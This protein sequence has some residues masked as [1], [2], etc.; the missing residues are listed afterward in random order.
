MAK[1]VKI[2]RPQLFG[3]I[4]T[5]EEFEFYTTE[6]F[7]LLKS[8]ELKTKVYKTYPLEDVAKAH[9]VSF[10]RMDLILSSS[11]GYSCG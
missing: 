1:N 7:R 3:Y 6:L 4:Q 9:E 11:L 10:N 8:G 5:R 2:A